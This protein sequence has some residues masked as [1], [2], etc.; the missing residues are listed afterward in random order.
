MSEIRRSYCGLC[1]PRCGTLLHIEDGRIVK[2]TGDPEHPVTRGVICE[3][4]RLMPDHVHHPRRLNY[5]LKRKGEKGGGQWQRLTWEHVRSPYLNGAIPIGTFSGTWDTYDKTK[6]D[7]REVFEDQILSQVQYN[8]GTLYITGT[9]ATRWESRPAGNY[10][11]FQA[12]DPYEVRW[13]IEIADES[14]LI[15][16]CPIGVGLRLYHNGH[17]AV[18]APA[19]SVGESQGITASDAVWFD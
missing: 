10:P 9:H 11:G 19:G 17:A 1:H 3:R 12:I 15:K 8:G 7:Y 5:P 14:K 16:V 4:G 6:E 2:V 18:D 13:L